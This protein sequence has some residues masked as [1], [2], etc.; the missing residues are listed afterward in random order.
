MSLYEKNAW[1]SLGAVVAL[2]IWYFTSVLGGDG[3]GDLAG[4]VGELITVVVAIVVIELVAEIALMATSRC[5]SKDERDS[6]IE[7]RANIFGL[8]SLAA[9]VIWIIIQ[10]VIDGLVVEGVETVARTS[11]VNALIAALVV[12]E[13]I[14]Q[15]TQIVLYR[16]SA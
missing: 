10:L 13:V 3:P 4:M 1:V 8:F 2:G 6:A 12:A 7:G 15:G 16:R 14:T 9:G 11:V 5:R